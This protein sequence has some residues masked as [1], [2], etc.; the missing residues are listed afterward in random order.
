[1]KPSS[2]P[3]LD[4][5]LAQLESIDPEERLEAI[6]QVRRYAGNRK[7][8][9]AVYELRNDGDRRVRTIAREIM[10]DGERRT[11]ESLSIPGAADREQEERV[12]EL[13]AD[14]RHAQAF[15]RV[16]ALKQLRL[17]P[18]NPKIEAAILNLRKD[19]D[20]TVRLMIEQMLDEQ[21]KTKVEGV[22]PEVNDF[23]DGVLVASPYS[24][25]SQKA[26]KESTADRFGPELIPY[27]G[28]FYFA[29]G[30][31]LLLA[32]SWLWSATQGVLKPEQMPDPSIRGGLEELL[33]IHADPLNLAIILLLTGLQTIGGLGTMFRRE[34]GRKMVLLFHTLMALAGL[35]LP[36]VWWKIFFGTFM[37]IVLY[38]LTRREIVKAFKGNDEERPPGPPPKYGE[39]ERKVW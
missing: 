26:W 33:G 23:Q 2:S 36:S 16:G 24:K 30:L 14:L 37:T 21:A 19:P 9:Q 38:F 4:A 5:L 29:L 27:V 25:K 17:M 7:V 15:E 13:L 35:F 32:S 10:E 3:G 8:T 6:Q 39:I 22:R 28:F 11:S 18:P 31:P 20:R 12:E 34:W 1:M